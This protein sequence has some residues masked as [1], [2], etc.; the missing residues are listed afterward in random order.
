MVRHR[1]RVLLMFLTTVTVSFLFGKQHDTV[2]STWLKTEFGYYFISWIPMEKDLAETACTNLGGCFVKEVC[3]PN[4]YHDNST[5][6]C[7]FLTRELTWKESLVECNRLK[8]YLNKDSLNE[9]GA[10]GTSGHLWID[11]DLFNCSIVNYTDDVDNETS[12]NCSFKTKGLC[13]RTDVHN[14]T[15][16]WSTTRDDTWQNGFIECN[17]NGGQMSR[18]SKLT[19]YDGIVSAVSV[20]NLY[21]IDT[22]EHCPGDT[23]CNEIKKAICKR[24]VYKN[25]GVYWLPIGQENFYISHFEQTFTLARMFCYVA[26]GTLA[27]TG[28]NLAVAGLDYTIHMIIREVNGKL[29]TMLKT[30]MKNISSAKESKIKPT[31]PKSTTATTTTQLTR[32]VSTTTIS[33]TNYCNN[34]K[35]WKMIHQMKYYISDVKMDYKTADDCCY[36]MGGYLYEFSALDEKMKNEFLKIGEQYWIGTDDNNF[37]RAEII[38][39][40]DPNSCFQGKPFEFK[41]IL[42]VE[43]NLIS[44]RNIRIELLKNDVTVDNETYEANGFRYPFIF[45]HT[46]ILEIKDMQ[47]PWKCK[48]VIDEM[49]LYSKEKIL[50]RTLYF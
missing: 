28:R 43:E 15:F 19:I 11:S 42:D 7:Y 45:N 6:S 9:G 16:F 46:K 37:T 33:N 2:S 17:K 23:D 12:R 50:A 29:S 38:L 18:S 44:T 39:K 22:L 48:A 13:F 3:P 1:Y 21:W 27:F 30:T 25:D 31:A 40:T 35:S 34:H 24:D 49:I 36:A 4:G 14:H 32:T 47:V 8:G 41:C 5:N 20:G 26:G 10:N